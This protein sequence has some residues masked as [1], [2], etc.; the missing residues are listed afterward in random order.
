[1]AAEQTLSH[2][3][4][5]P[6]EAHRL[7][8]MTRGLAAIVTTEGRMF[9][10][11]T[12]EEEDPRLQVHNNPNRDGTPLH[13]NLPSPGESFANMHVTGGPPRQGETPSGLSPR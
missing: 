8:K 10:D 6:E 1:M 9:R 2:P 7:F 4:P 13:G 11:G 5:T 12:F 3:D